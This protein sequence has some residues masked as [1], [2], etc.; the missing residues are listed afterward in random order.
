MRKSE[1][2]DS[3]PVFAIQIKMLVSQGRFSLALLDHVYRHGN[4]EILTNLKKRKALEI[5]KQELFNYG[6]QGEYHDGM[7]EASFEIGQERNR[8][9]EICNNWVQSNYPYFER[10]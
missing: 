4:E 5:L 6:M 8:L 1:L 7:F 9:S 2:V 10:T 3:T